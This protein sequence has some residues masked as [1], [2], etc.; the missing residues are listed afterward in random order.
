M[1]PSP[2]LAHPHP[3]ISYSLN[4]CQAKLF[5][6]LTPTTTAVFCLETTIIPADRLTF[7]TPMED[8]LNHY[9]LLLL[10]CQCNVN[11]PPG[12]GS[13]EYLQAD[14]DVKEKEKRSDSKEG[15]GNRTMPTKRY[16]VWRA[17][18]DTRRDA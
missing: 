4:V 2:T 3:S 6:L 8:Y 16:C 12:R 11:V 18:S 9:I 7:S 1:P 14:A 5:E 10:D 13:C 17:S 15:W